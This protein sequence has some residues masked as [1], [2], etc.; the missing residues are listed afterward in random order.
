M[1]L[2]RRARVGSAIF[3]I[4]GITFAGIAAMHFVA[5]HLGSFDS[6]L[7][8]AGQA[9]SAQVAATIA[10]VFALLAVAISAAFRRT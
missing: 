5:G 10:V 1:D 7:I 4:V 9:Q 3:M 2:Q 6:G 8:D